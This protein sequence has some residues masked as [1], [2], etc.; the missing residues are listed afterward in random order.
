MEHL[1][2][3]FRKDEQPFIEKVVG[4]KRE[5][6]DRFVPKLTDFLDPR[7]RFIV[8]SIVGQNEHFSVKTEGVFNEA[9]RQRLLIYPPYFQPQLE[10]FGITLFSITYPSKFVQLAH[11]DVLGSLLSLGI[12]RAK[13]GDIRVHDEIIQFS[14]ASE[15]SDY[16]QSNLMTIGKVKVQIEQIKGMDSLIQIK[17]E[18]LEKVYTVS[19]MRLDVILATIL[20]ISRQ[21]SQAL[22]QAGKVKVNWTIR[23][24][25]S[26]EVQEGDLISARGFGRL[27]VMMIEGKTKK[28]KIRIQ[29]G[30]LQQK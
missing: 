1:I 28:D 2:Q 30:K 24:E 3:H 22:I 8:F 16:V 20:N 13:F 14:V 9:E 21:K 27:K 26:F 6:E 19:S 10:D 12:G 15:V 17:E 25:T 11:R 5:V 4:W 29:M 18:W 23:E 7:E